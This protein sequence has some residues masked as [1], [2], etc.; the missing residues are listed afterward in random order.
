VP[1]RI[2][3]TSDVHLGSLMTASA[4]RLPAAKAEQ[5]RHELREV[6]GRACRLAVDEAV[7]ALLIP[8]DLFDDEAVSI[9]DLGYA[10]EQLGALGRPVVIAPGNHDYISP[11]SPYNPVTLHNRH[12]LR[13][14]ANVHI[15]QRQT[16]QT[17][18][19]P[20]LPC[21]SFTGLALE[22]HVPLTKRFV[23]PGICPPDGIGVLM[24]HGSYERGLPAG[25]LA[26]LP[27][28]DAELAA[29]G[30]AYA[31]IGHYH[32]PERWPAPTAGS[33][34]PIRAARP[35][36]ASTSRAGRSYLPERSTR[37]AALG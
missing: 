18:R 32:S 17:L 7:D 24:F 29:S 5:R 2:V 37:R 4:L 33:W 27:F 6:F 21:V 25:K 3:Q 23:T 12:G 34:A 9:D 28:T 8:G 11:A 14:S 35:G 20:T 36:G 10:I 15:F 22:T 31:A 30:C 13:W 26:T 19:L 1:F 16:W